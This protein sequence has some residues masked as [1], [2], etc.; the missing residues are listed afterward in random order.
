MINFIDNGLA[1]SYFVF[2]LVAVIGLLQ[3]VAAHRNLVGLSLIPGARRRVFG[4][5]LGSTFTLGSFP[6]FFVVEYTGIFRP[7]PAGLELLVLFSGATLAGLALTLIGAS[8]VQRKQGAALL[9]LETLPPDVGSEEVDAGHARAT[10]YF[11]GGPAPWPALCVLSDPGCPPDVLVPLARAL[12]HGGYAVLLLRPDC[13]TTWRYPEVLALAPT[14]CTLLARRADIAGDRMGLLGFGL[15]ADL[16]LRSGS[17]DEQV[18]VV[19]ALA[20]LLD[21]A[22]ALA[23]LGALQEMTLPQAVRWA[24]FRSYSDLLRQLAPLEHGA[25]IDE[26][27]GVLFVYGV[28]DGLVDTQQALAAVRRAVP[29]AQFEALAGQ[30]HSDLLYSEVTAEVVLGWLR[31]RL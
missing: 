7:G 21:R 11:P 23:G 5:L 4:Y 10:L 16:A 22:N 18:K 29:G 9:T 17:T 31:G 6:V 26:G 8:L 2:S 3:L 14:A 15:G 24:R 13:E 28:D 30:G 19:V 1:A 25:R 27:A 20:P 12:A